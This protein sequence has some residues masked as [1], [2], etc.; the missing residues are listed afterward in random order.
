[1]TSV[2][3]QAHRPKLQCRH[4][5]ISKMETNPLTYILLGAAFALALIA[6]QRIV[7]RVT[8]QGAHRDINRGDRRTAIRRLEALSAFA[9][10]GTIEQSFAVLFLLTN[11]YLHEK[12]YQETIATCR[13]FL[14]A[15]V[16]AKPW[17]S[18]YES[19][20]PTALMG[21]IRTTKQSPSGL[22]R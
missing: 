4:F 1:M 5:F 2:D 3:Q 6:V 22:Q 9:F 11:L 13:R 19:A 10:I 7:W 18:K 21:L 8:V 20:S 16:P 14:K 12:R 15:K 17:K